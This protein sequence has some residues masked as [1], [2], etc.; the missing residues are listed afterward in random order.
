MPEENKMVSYDTIY[1]VVMSD[2]YA[3]FRIRQRNNQDGHSRKEY[4]MYQQVE[5]LAKLFG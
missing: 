3:D 2:L 5:N 1:N 4:T